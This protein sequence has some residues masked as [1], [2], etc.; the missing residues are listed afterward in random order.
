MNADKEFLYKPILKEIAGI[1]NPILKKA[2]SYQKNGPQ[3]T[4]LK[5]LIDEDQ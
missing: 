4:I 2:R 1:L 3:R 5:E